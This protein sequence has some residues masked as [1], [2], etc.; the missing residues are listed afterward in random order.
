MFFLTFDNKKNTDIGFRCQYVTKLSKQILNN[1]A[2]LTT[3]L[4]TPIKQRLN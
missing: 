1:K 4:N 3:G 2:H